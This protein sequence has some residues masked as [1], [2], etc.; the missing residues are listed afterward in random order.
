MSSR[1][2][3]FALALGVVSLFA[4]APAAVAQPYPAKPIRIVVPFPAGGIADIY[5]RI[6]GNRL[7]ETW[8]QPVVIENRT[9]AGGNIAAELVAKS[10]PD[11]YSLVMGSLGTH[12]V[13]V[14]L[15]S[16]LPYDPVRDFAPIAQVLEA[17]SLLVV[18]PSVPVQSVPEL[19]AHARTFPGKLTFASAGMGT[20]SH[21]AGEL[22]KSMAKLEMTHVPYKGNVPAITDL[23][24]GQT[25]L[26]FATMPTV[27]PHA[28]AGKLRA[29]ATI[30][31]VRSAAAPELP[32]VAEAALPGFEVTNWIGL[33]APAGTSAEIVH[34][35]NAEVMRLMQSP[36]IQARTLG[37][38]ARSSPNTPEQFSAFV[39]AEIA[40]WAPVVR[41]SGARAD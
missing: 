39:K 36:E 32:T 12:A 22:F 4:W 30:G 17:E 27:L 2:C 13:N 37:E 7:T 20:A 14:T 26:I 41:A 9:G 15:F 25:S 10:P 18:H 6:I 34:R 8:A 28:K 23:L 29:L 19:I 21:L 1:T 5:A 38:G 3:R 35:L 31:A 24:A 33:F 11:G 40:K 16:K